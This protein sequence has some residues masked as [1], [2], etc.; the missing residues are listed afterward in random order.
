MIRKFTHRVGLAALLLGYSGALFAANAAPDPLF[1]PILDDLQQELPDGWQFRLP[2]TLPSDDELYPFISQASDTEVVVSL[3]LTPD[4]ADPSCA[5]GLIGVTDVEPTADNWPPTGENVTPVELGPGIEGYYLLR[6]EGEAMNQL[7]MWQQD[8][9]TYAIATLADSSSQEEFIEIARSMVSEPP[10]SASEDGMTEDNTLE[11][12]P[13]E[14]PMRP[15]DD[16]ESPADDPIRPDEAPM[17]PTDEPLD[18]SADPMSPMDQP[19]DP[20]EAPTAP[21]EELP[22]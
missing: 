3:A 21:L 19:T 20:V 6:G 8:G 12:I 15:I 18:P 2:S 22:E 16:L 14:E 13:S 9:L 17:S 11:E 10:I 4:C 7:V 1:E 5:I